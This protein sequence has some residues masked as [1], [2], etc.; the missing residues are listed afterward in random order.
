MP[1]R[2]VNRTVSPSSAGRL[3]RSDSLRSVSSGSARSD[4][5]LPRSPANGGPNDN[6]NNNNNN[7]GKSVSFNNNVRVQY[8]RRTSHSF[9]KF[10]S[11]TSLNGR[12][13]PI[14]SG[15]N[16][17][18]Y[19]NTNANGGGIP[20]AS[21]PH[22]LPPQSQNYTSQTL[23]HPNK[24]GNKKFWSNVWRSHSVRKSDDNSSP[25]IKY[26]VKHSSPLLSRKFVGKKQA[27]SESPQVRRNHV[28][29]I[30]N[31]FNRQAA[32]NKQKLREDQETTGPK[33]GLHDLQSASMPVPSMSLSRTSVTRSN[34]PAPRPS[35]SPSAPPGIAKSPTIASTTTH[36]GPT[37][38]KRTVT[39]TTYEPRPYEYVT[40]NNPLNFQSTSPHTDSSVN[41]SDKEN[42]SFQSGSSFLNRDSGISLAASPI[43]STS[44]GPFISTVT[45][46]HSPT[47]PRDQREPLL[48][49]TGQR[50]P[51]ELRHEFRWVPPF[52][53][54]GHLG[55][56]SSDDSLY[57]DSM[58]PQRPLRNKPSSALNIPPSSQVQ[59]PPPPMKDVAVQVNQIKPG[60][61]TPVEELPPRI[62]AP[63]YSQVNK[64]LKKTNSSP[65]PPP[66]PPTS[67]MPLP[68]RWSSHSQLVNSS[69]SPGWGSGHDM[70]DH[71]SNHCDSQS[72]QWRRYRS[73]SPPSRYGDNS[74]CTPMGLGYEHT[75][76]SS[77]LHSPVNRYSDLEHGNIHQ[78][79]FGLSDAESAPSRS[80][81][82]QSHVKTSSRSFGFNIGTK[83]KV[84]SKK[85][86]TT[87]E[88]DSSSTSSQGVSG[89]RSQ[90]MLRQTMA[91]RSLANPRGVRTQHYNSL[92]DLSPAYGR[93]HYPTYEDEYGPAPKPPHTYSWTLS[94][95]RVPKSKRSIDGSSTATGPISSTQT[96]LAQA[97]RKA[98][99][100]A[101]SSIDEDH[102]SHF[103]QGPRRG[104]LAAAFH[105][106]NT[107]G[108][109]FNSGAS[110][111]GS[112]TAS[113][114][115][116]VREPI[117]MYIPGV[118]RAKAPP[119]AAVNRGNSLLQQQSPEGRNSP[120]YNGAQ[121]GSCATLG[122]K[123]HKSRFTKQ[124]T[125]NGGGK[126][127]RYKKNKDREL[128]HHTAVQRSKSIPRNARFL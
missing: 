21:S 91:P 92:L 74:L 39:T 107:R 49:S 55:G 123:E 3:R 8:P 52:E 101:P 120:H 108:E 116:G 96:P 72:P 43:R 31:L 32:V 35:A 80:R 36:H 81:T 67:S 100:D 4:D 6:H 7:K 117:I 102:P 56:P 22:H 12:H 45:L 19:S 2:G 20:Y 33:K 11:L 94:L 48:S 78:S 70:R 44:P 115:A 40:F 87:Q 61:L 110:S 15:L 88:S 127:D 41:T 27:G 17:I 51:S 77:P 73:G 64:A 37:S 86:K 30:V 14:S 34:S 76:M 24:G 122:R 46:N 53:D 113:E 126:N 125:K 105:H 25:V 13:S 26:K 75:S 103:S 112:V 66:P 50:D 54:G 85:S 95:G 65:P 84:K 59:H 99:S 57:S 119:D 114:A 79:D 109:A 9:S 29:K 118:Q 111:C 90:S 23:E 124:E 38:I 28:K 97:A 71:S 1:L 106:R 68:Q 121:H 63:L 82:P 89:D 18:D 104:G 5:S 47:T 16:E 42:S 128:E 98:Y 10:D 69:A 58:P 62:Y 83:K 93:S 60:N